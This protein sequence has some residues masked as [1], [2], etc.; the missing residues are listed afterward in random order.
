[1]WLTTQIMG[2]LALP[3]A[4]AF[5]A[6]HGIDVTVSRAAARTIGERLV[7]S[8]RSRQTAI[9]II[10]G[11]SAIPHLKR[12]GLLAPLDSTLRQLL[13]SELVDPEGYWLAT[14]AYFSGIAVNTE[15]VPLDA[16]PRKLDDLLDPRWSGRIVWSGQA[17]IS[18]DAG[19]IG[20]VL[21]DRG[22]SAGRQFLTS[23]ARQQITTL[24][25]S[26]RQ[27]VDKVIAGVFPLALQVFHHQ[28][29]ISA[30]RGAPVA[31]LPVE[32]MTGSMTALA[33]TRQSAS[34]NAARLFIEFLVSRAGQEIF[35]D[36]DY[37]PALPGVAAKDAALQP[38]NGGFRA[39]YFTPEETEAGMPAWQ[40]VRAELFR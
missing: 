32:P 10:D 4:A 2:E 9:D 1:M 5:K 31:W 21:R 6:S 39:V 14:N 24:D 13:P 16:R 26:S 29:S 37:I 23:L 15:Q 3:L 11:R 35:R 18:S 25:I 28:A 36:A 19:F 8:A 12:A 30:G 40:A 33:M 34:P 27:V 7:Q 22:E 20:A 38:A 17:T